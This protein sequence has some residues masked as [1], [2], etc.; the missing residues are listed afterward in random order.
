MKPEKPKVSTEKIVE[1]ME[2]ALQFVE[3][4]KIST[5]N[6]ISSLPERR[7]RRVI[8]QRKLQKLIS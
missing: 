6:T 3:D 2:L 4:M 7:S 5:P 8:Q 1:K